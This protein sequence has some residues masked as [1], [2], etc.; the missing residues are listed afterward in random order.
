MRAIFRLECKQVG[1]QWSELKSTFVDFVKLLL[2]PFYKKTTYYINNNKLIF[3]GNVSK[4]LVG[5]CY[6]TYY[7]F[8][9][10]IF[11]TILSWTSKEGLADH[12]H[13]VLNSTFYWAG[14]GGSGSIWNF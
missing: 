7:A 9:D 2:N 3:L 13:S 10:Q 1:P 8:V 6:L 5:S 12:V 4:L 14:K 11:R